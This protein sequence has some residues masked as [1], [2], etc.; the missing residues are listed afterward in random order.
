MIVTKN[1]GHLIVSSSYWGSE[2]ESAGKLYVSCNAGAIRMLVPSSM[3]DVIE[4]ARKARYVVLSRGP[5]PSLGKEEAAEIMFE[6]GSDNP[7]V[8]H[9]GPESFDLMPADPG[10][11]RE[12]VLAIWDLKK[13]RPH[14]AVERPCHWRRVEKIP[15]MM[16]WG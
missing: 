12:W 9:L 8:I 5:W 6:D 15:C 3:R 10:T 1:H 11:G 4:E 16:P 2:L 7:Y 14:K 13:G